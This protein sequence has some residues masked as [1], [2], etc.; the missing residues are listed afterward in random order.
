MK[1]PP[2]RLTLMYVK[3][4]SVGLAKCSCGAPSPA[5]AQASISGLRENHEE[6][7][8]ENVCDHQADRDRIKRVLEPL[9][10]LFE[11]STKAH[12]GR[13]RLVDLL[14]VA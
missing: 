13:L 11:M 8:L 3:N 10:Q 2:S 12:G 9:A 5:S 6:R 1:M 7:L 4:G 14:V